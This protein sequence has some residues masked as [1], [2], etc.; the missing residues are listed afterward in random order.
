[1]KADLPKLRNL[2]IQKFNIGKLQTSNR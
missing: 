1:M 2:L